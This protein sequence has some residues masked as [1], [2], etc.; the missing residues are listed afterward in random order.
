M[1]STRLSGFKE[2]F[3]FLL[4]FTAEGIN[5]QNVILANNKGAGFQS[6]LAAP[7][8]LHV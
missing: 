2:H 6:L 8:P 7:L 3:I 1:L 4:V 5:T